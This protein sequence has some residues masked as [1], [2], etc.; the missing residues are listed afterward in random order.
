[1][2][3][4]VESGNSRALCFFALKVEDPAVLRRQ[5][6][7]KGRKGLPTGYKFTMLRDSLLTCG[8]PTCVFNRFW[9]FSFRFQRGFAAPQ[10][11]PT[12]VLKR[13]LYL[14]ATFPLCSGIRL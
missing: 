1:M 12:L 2:E 6:R 13:H 3:V 14:L 10:T 4:G 5:G 9:F 8:M 7:K 11:R